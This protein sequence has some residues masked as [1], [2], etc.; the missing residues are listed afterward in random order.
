MC[1]ILYSC[2][3]HVIFDLYEP[4]R[5]YPYSYVCRCYISNLIEIRK[6]VLEIGASGYYKYAF[7]FGIYPENK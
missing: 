7:I 4:K 3:T 5:R 6:S 1:C 2:K